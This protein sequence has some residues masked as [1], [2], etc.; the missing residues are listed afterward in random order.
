[1]QNAYRGLGYQKGDLPVTEEVAG[2][3]LSLPMYP[4]LSRNEQESVVEAVLECL[5]EQT[6]S[7]ASSS[8]L[9]A[10]TRAEFAA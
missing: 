3:I 5:A 1:L 4:G 6:E 2:E 7:E 9:G 10:A 8:A